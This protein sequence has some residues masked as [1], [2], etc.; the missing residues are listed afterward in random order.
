LPC[1]EL[2]HDVGDLGTKSSKHGIVPE[3]TV[4][5]YSIRRNASVFVVLPNI[6]V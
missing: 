5:L 4:F 2:K 3:L 6:Y 1:G